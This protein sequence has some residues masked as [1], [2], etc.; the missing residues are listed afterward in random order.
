[1]FNLVYKQY[2]YHI[3]VLNQI[4]VVLTC[5][6]NTPDAAAAIAL[7]NLTTCIPMSQLAFSF[8]TAIF[9]IGGLVGSL[10]ANLVID[11]SG[12]RATHRLCAV[13]TLIGTAFIGMGSSLFP[14]LFGR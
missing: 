14:L 4:H 5:Q 13:L 3:S 8:V 1:M 9:T 10:V 7:P 2:G 12:R 6:Q 11:A